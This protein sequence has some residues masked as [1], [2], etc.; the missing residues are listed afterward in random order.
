MGSLGW[1]GRLFEVVVTD[2]VRLLV[3]FVVG[4]RVGKDIF[5]GLIFGTTLTICLLKEI[6]CVL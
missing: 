5:D 3:G 2:G 6:M 1:R 4:V